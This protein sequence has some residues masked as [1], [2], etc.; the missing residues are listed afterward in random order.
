MS[1]VA[2]ATRRRLGVVFGEAQTACFGDEEC[3]E[4]RDGTRVARSEIDVRQLTL[5]V[6]EPELREERVVRE[7]GSVGLAKGAQNHRRALLE[8][9]ILRRR[10]KTRPQHRAERTVAE[11]QPPLAQLRIELPLRLGGK[12]V[13]EQRVI[14]VDSARR[15]SGARGSRAGTYRP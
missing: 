12:A 7:R 8:K 6:G 3:V 14:F 13:G 2:G 5:P 9:A 11:E 10:Q 15:S 4:P 1:V